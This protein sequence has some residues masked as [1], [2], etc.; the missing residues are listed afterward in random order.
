M[1][2]WLD[3]EVA[4]TQSTSLLY[5]YVDCTTSKE[6]TIQERTV[7]CSRK[8]APGIHNTVNPVLTRAAK[9]KSS[10]TFDPGGPGTGPS[11][12]IIRHRRKFLEYRQR[13]DDEPV[14]HYMFRA[15]NRSKISQS[16]GPEYIQRKSNDAQTIYQTNEQ[17]HPMDDDEEDE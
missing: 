7:E 8:E 4:L 5:K 14:F 17:L 11:P 13:V 3:S 15:D 9:G 16:T 10:K 2:L 12:F 1:V 6:A